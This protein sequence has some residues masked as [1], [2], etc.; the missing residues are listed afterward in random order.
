VEAPGIARRLAGFVYEGVLLFGVVMIAGLMYSL[1]T[2]QRHAL[3]GSVGLQL[4]LFFVLGAYFVYFWSRHG[5][6]LAMKTWH[7]RL[8]APD[9][10]P[11]GC[12][13]CAVRYLL[14]WM[15]FLPALALAALSGLR[16]GVATAGV[17]GVGVLA[18]AALA[19]LRGDRQ[20]FHDAL[21]GTRIVDDHVTTK[22][23]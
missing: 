20:Y 8:V 11:P 6:T 21:C 17:I 23:R 2:N 18:Y 22:R 12:G 9:G 13:R 3:V 7:M 1:A 5:Q 14:A 4:T 15:W 16:G 10:R 19:Y